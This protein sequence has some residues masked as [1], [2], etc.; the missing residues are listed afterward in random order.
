MR[1]GETDYNKREQLQGSGINSSLNDTGRRQADLLKRSSSLPVSDAILYSS[2]LSRAIETGQ[3]VTDRPVGD[4][5]LDDRLKERSFGIWEGKFRH[6]VGQRMKEVGV[7]AVLQFFFRLKCLPKNL[8]Y[9][10]KP[11]ASI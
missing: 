11:Y 5:K 2:P 1:H 9:D 7:R 4:F 6:E 10:Q 3:I 8:T